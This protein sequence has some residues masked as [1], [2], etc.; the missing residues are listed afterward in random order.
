M[1]TLIVM[2][3][4]SLPEMKRETFPEFTTGTVQ[5]SIPYP[6]ATAEEVENGICR[7]IEDALDSVNNLDELRCEARESVAIAFADIQEGAQI[8]KSF[9]M[10]S[11]A[12][13]IR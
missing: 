13:S 10:I 1:L 7:I 9:S 11:I 8:T 2:G 6:G 5:I 4:M 3:L 12:L